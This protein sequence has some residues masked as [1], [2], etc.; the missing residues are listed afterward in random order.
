MNE[1]HRDEDWHPSAVDVRSAMSCL[2]V[3]GL[4]LLL[5]DNSGIVV[6]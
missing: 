2:L 4:W 1:A 5:L 6:D 3:L